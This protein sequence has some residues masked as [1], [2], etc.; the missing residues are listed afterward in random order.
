M[1][2]I[3]KNSGLE[4]NYLIDFNKI[5]YIYAL[6]LAMAYA[7]VLAFANSNENMTTSVL[8]LAQGVY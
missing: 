1:S 8:H 2:F 6:G 4:N 3:V 5:I 7:I